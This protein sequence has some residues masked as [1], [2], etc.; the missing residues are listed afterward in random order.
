MLL[1]S[2]LFFCCLWATRDAWKEYRWKHNLGVHGEELE[3]AP[4]DQ[5]QFTRAPIN[6]PQQIPATRLLSRRAVLVGLTTVLIVGNGIAWSLLISSKRRQGSSSPGLGKA[7]YVYRGHKGRVRSVAWSPH[8][9]YIASGSDDKTLQVWEAANGAHNLTFAGLASTVSAVAWSPVGTRI[10]SGETSDGTMQVWDVTSGRNISTFHTPSDSAVEVLAWSPDGG[11]IVSANSIGGS[12]Q[13]TNTGSLQ[14]S[15]NQSLQVW[16]IANRGHS[17]S[18]GLG[19]DSLAVVWSSDGKHIS[20]VDDKGAI[21]VLDVPT[22]QSTFPFGIYGLSRGSSLAMFTAAAYSL[23]GKHIALAKDDK[24]VEVWDSSGGKRVYT[25]RGHANAAL[26]FISALAWSPDGRRIAS[27][28]ADKAVQVWDAF[29]GEHVYI[30]RGHSDAVTTVAWSPDG[31]YI[32]LG[33]AD[34]TVQVW[35]AG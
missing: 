20:S 7:L 24:M 31:K 12:V 21:E 18:M 28:S 4:E 16:D 23:D 1:A 2:L 30:Y 5:N 9:N 35:D 19:G 25:Y 26:G 11:H 29:N 34:K 13:V 14:P 32:A 3:V 27:G 33:S 17:F 22:R 10:A 6:P 8:G 15:E